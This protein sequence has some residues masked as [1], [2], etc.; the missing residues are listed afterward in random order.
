MDTENESELQRNLSLFAFT[1]LCSSRGIAQLSLL[2][3]R[4]ICITAC[5]PSWLFLSLSW[6]KPW[7]R[8]ERFSLRALDLLALL[9]SFSP[10]SL[11]QRSL[12]QW[13]EPYPTPTRLL[14]HH[15]EV[16]GLQP[17]LLLLLPPCASSPHPPLIHQEWHLAF[18][19]LLIAKGSW[20]LLGFWEGHLTL[21][22]RWRMSQRKSRGRFLIRKEAD[23]LY[24]YYFCWYWSGAASIHTIFMRMFLLGE[25]EF[26]QAL[27]SFS[28]YVF[29]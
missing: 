11:R 18:L 23:L 22:Y 25:C 2:S 16:L 7:V 29:F 15:V 12:G 27:A 3:K 24:D 8:A 28:H 5:A 26:Q 4:A 17:L 6:R 9:P 1:F 14:R 20:I 13:T 19:S 21:E 10:P